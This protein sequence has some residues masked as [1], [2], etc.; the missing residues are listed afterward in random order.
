VTRRDT[1]KPGRIMPAGLRGPM[2]GA[3]KR[4]PEINL[5]LPIIPYRLRDCVA[6]APFGLLRRRYRSIGIDMADL[7]PLLVQC[8]S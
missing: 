5:F 1:A 3:P 4:N 6:A 8:I 7:L 2:F